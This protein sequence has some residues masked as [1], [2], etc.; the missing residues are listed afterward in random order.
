M[1][2]VSEVRPPGLNA[3]KQ[4]AQNLLNAVEQYEQ[5]VKQELV[6]KDGK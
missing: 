3:V 5:D 2:K 6:E 4:F 1:K